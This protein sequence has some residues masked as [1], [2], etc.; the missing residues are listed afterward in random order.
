MTG[1][2]EDDVLSGVVQIGLQRV[3]R[4]DEL[5]DINQ[6]GGVG[7]LSGGGIDFHLSPRLKR[8]PKAQHLRLLV[9]CSM[10]G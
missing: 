6:D 3:V 10:R 4:R 9:A 7:R 1:R 5:W 8:R 2:A